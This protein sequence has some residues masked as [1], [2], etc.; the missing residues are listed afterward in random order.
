M[1][2]MMDAIFGKEYIVWMA[3]IPGDLDSYWLLLAKQFDDSI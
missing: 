1:I 2:V 3:L